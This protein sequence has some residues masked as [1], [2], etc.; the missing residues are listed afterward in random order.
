M[1][2]LD[3]KTYQ[4]AKEKFKW[5]GVWNMFDG[6]RDN[7]NIAHECIDRHVG[8]GTAARIKFSDGHTEEYSFDEICSKSSK[9]ANALKRLGIR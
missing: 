7:F 9:F 2:I 3:Y 5:S 6:T 4:E 1:S 8:K